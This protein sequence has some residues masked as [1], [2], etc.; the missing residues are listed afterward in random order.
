MALRPLSRVCC[1]ACS[2]L[3][4]WRSPASLSSIGRLTPVITSTCC[5][6]EERQAEV[7]RRA[8]EHVGEHDDAGRPRHP[9]DRG[10]DRLARRLDVVVPADRDGDEAASSSPTIIS[11]ALTSSVASWPWVT[12]TTPMSGAAR[13]V[14]HGGRIRRARSQALATSR[15]L[16]RRRTPV[17]AAQRLGQR[18]GDGHRSMA[19]AGAADGDGQV[20]LALAR[21]A[22]NQELQ[23]VGDLAR[24]R[25]RCPRS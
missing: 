1:A 23:Q 10:G 21:V 3:S 6:A 17:E 20:A 22:R 5:S 18:F 8:A 4:A 11:A 19:A 24:G 13:R 2:R 7:G 16:T 9:R 15:C 14:D 12:T 25:R